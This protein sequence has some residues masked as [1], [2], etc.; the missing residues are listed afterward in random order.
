MPSPQFRNVLFTIYPDLLDDQLDPDL[1]HGYYEP[2]WDPTCMS[3]LVYQ[4][5]ECPDTGNIHW[6]GYAEF[7]KKMTRNA[8]QAALYMGKKFHFEPRRGTPQQAREYCMKD[9][10]SLGA[11][12][13]YGVLSNPGQRTD[14]NVVKESIMNG[15]KVEE[16]MMSNPLIYHQYGRTL[17]A[18]EDVVLRSKKRNHMTEGIW[19]WG[20]TGAG[21]SHKA[22]TEHGDDFYVKP[23]GKDTDWW[24]GYKGQ[25]V[26]IFNEFRGQIDYAQVLQLLDKWPHVVSRRGREPMPFLAKKIIFT[27]TTLP[28]GI[29]KRQAEKVDSLDQLYRRLTTV[30]KVVRDAGGEE[31]LDIVSD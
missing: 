2:I 13:E 27:C 1:W 26:V 4:L 8:V 16:I 25:S 7:T 18:I 29:Y 28:E 22:F 5:E 24:D 31:M 20:D 21:K 30:V 12:T 19:Y 17:N 23:W 15:T 11:Q 14:L 3:Y 10:T 6:Q 9:E